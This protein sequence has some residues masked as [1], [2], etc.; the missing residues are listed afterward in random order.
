MAIKKVNE[1]APSST[2]ELTTQY[3]CGPKHKDRMNELLMLEAAHIVWGIPVVGI[4][5]LLFIFRGIPIYV[6]SGI[7]HG[8][9]FIGFR[10]SF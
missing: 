9:V 10:F 6:V 2:E 3:Q 7:G 4:V 8:L 1:G 5:V